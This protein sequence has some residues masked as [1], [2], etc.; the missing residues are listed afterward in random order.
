MHIS[1]IAMSLKT[2]GRNMNAIALVAVVDGADSPVADA[3]VTG[4]WSG[5]T[6]DS[7]SGTTDSDGLV[8][9]SSDRVKKSTSG[10]FTFTVDSVILSG[11]DYDPESNVVDSG[12][13][14]TP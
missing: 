12:S 3:K 11:W 2:A 9:L 10:T 14:S 5:L 7:D 1:D 13:I 6:D 4:H 8:S